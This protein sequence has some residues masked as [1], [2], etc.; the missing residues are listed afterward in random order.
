MAASASGLPA[1][2]RSLAVEA[3]VCAFSNDSSDALDKL[4]APAAR[5]VHAPSLDTPPRVSSAVQAQDSSEDGNHLF[6]TASDSPLHAEDLASS[7]LDRCDFSEETCIQI[8][9][10]TFQL[11]VIMNRHGGTLGHARFA[12]YFCVGLFRNRS[13]WGLTSWCN[14][15]PKPV[16]YLNAFLSALAP[17]AEWFAL[18]IS[19]DVPTEVHR[20]RK[21]EPTLVSCIFG[22]RQWWG[23]LAG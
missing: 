18:V 20:D 15:V 6:S 17:E 7:A 2:Q 10:A 23:P 12:D 14:K 19:A 9:Q 5:M 13:V 16:C 1:R 11:P 4:P 3:E 22:T 8:L 21:N